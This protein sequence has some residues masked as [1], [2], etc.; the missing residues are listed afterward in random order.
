MIYIGF[1][2][3]L[4]LLVLVVLVFIFGDGLDFVIGIDL[5]IMYLW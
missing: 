2:I 5:G 4:F 3:L 1:M